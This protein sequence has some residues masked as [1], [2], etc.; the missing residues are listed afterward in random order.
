MSKWNIVTVIGSAVGMI[1]FLL[2]M[3]LPASSENKAR[4]FCD[5]VVET[6]LTS[7]DSVEVTRAGFLVQNLGCGVRKRLP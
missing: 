1:S 4:K 5:Q 2:L 3:W 7:D 6:L